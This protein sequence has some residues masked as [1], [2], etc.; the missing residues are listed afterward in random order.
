MQRAING[1]NIA[2]RQHILQIL[3]SSAANLLLKLGLERLVVEVEQLF[4][5]ESLQSPQD[6]LSDAA[7]S[8]G[9]NDLIL[10]V[11]LAFCDG[12]NVPVSSCDLLMSGDEIADEDEDGHDDM[13]GNGDNIRSSDFSDGDSAI[14]L[15]GGIKVD[16]VGTDAGSDGKLELLRLGEAFGGQVARVEAV[17]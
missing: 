3:H 8:D 13:F 6:T 17:I 2:L 4:A 14:G 1:N 10:K 16:V 7:D 11:I 9:T 15:V 12:G 5:I